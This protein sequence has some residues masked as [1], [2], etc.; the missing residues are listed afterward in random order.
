M[1]RLFVDL[2][3]EGLLSTLPLVS[4]TASLLPCT[5]CMVCSSVL[6]WI[7]PGSPPSKLAAKMPGFFVC[8]VEKRKWLGGKSPGSSFEK[9]GAWAFECFGSR[10]G[11][12][13]STCD[14][15]EIWKRSC[16]HV[17]LPVQVQVSPHSPRCRA[18]AESPAPAAGGGEAASELGPPGDALWGT[19]GPLR[20]ALR[21]WWCRLCVRCSAADRVFFLIYLVWFLKT[22]V[23]WAQAVLRSL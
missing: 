10:A 16:K 4:P 19:R 8:M 3:T 18:Q 11:F 20:A 23:K 2:G 17:V 13:P 6:P 9:C 21:S 5:G 1:W 22:S 15:V 12:C 7:A 14:S